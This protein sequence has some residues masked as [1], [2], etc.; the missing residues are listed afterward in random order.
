MSVSDFP[1]FSLA[2]T[3]TPLESMPNLTR[4]LAGLIGMVRSGHFKSGQTVLY[5]HT[6]GTPTVFGYSSIFGD[7]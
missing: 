1:R 6:G 4:L 5:L 7:L 3:P 2:H